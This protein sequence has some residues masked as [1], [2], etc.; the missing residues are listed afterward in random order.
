MSAQNI[1]NAFSYL[2]E[3]HPELTAQNQDS[4]RQLCRG[5]NNLDEVV[6][7]I[8]KWCKERGVYDKLLELN[9]ENLPTKGDLVCLEEP[10]AQV[11]EVDKLL[12]ANWIK[13][14]QENKNDPSKNNDNNQTKTGTKKP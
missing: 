13:I 1:I 11:A 5:K 9:K 8:G 4:I 10:N 2:L 3:N 14:S 7:A 12:I 6:G